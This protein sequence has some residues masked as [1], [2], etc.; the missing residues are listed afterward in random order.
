MLLKCYMREHVGNGLKRCFLTY[1]LR[2]IKLLD[3]LSMLAL[4]AFGWVF[5]WL[6]CA[7]IF[8]R[9]LFVCFSNVESLTCARNHG[10]AL[11]YL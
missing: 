10:H 2:L 4:S 11:I 5:L 3:N 1:L 9:G 8:W 6:L 7:N